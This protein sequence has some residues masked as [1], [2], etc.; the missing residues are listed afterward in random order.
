MRLRFLIPGILILTG[1][2]NVGLRFLPPEHLALRSWE[3]VTLFVTGAGPFA[4]N[5]HYVNAAAPG[6]L[7]TLANQPQYSHPHVESFTTGRQGYRGYDPD[8]DGPPAA[9]LFG[10][11]FG[12]GGSLADEDSLCA[13]LR[14]VFGGPVFF[15][16]Y[17]SP[18][19]PAKLASLPRAPYV[20]LQLSERYPVSDAPN[21]AQGISGLIRRSVDESSDLFIKI[22]YLNSLTVYSPLEI[23]AGRVYRYLQNDEILPN[24]QAASVDRY[25][26]RNQTEMLFLHSEISQL[27]SPP[28]IELA[29][30]TALEH[31]LETHGSHVIVVLVPNKLTVYYPLIPGFSPEPVE[32]RLYINVLERELRQASIPVVNLTATL[33]RTAAAALAKNELIYHPDD[34][35]WNAA[36]VMAAS[37]EIARVINRGD[38]P[39]SAH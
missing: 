1:I 4:P 14:P 32:D 5:K 28:P 19:L 2:A 35:H 38:S 27:F 16:A 26:L 34:T 3:A 36:G 31:Q 7:G 18:K 6:D 12:A 9:I 13:R 15:G 17:Y 30:L 23:W 24:V 39:Q 20:I 25:T 8:A 10:D 11:S 21:V 22:R 37:A 29:G 33:Q